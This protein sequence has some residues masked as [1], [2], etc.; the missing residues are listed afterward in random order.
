MASLVPADLSAKNG[1]PSAPTA[2]PNAWFGLGYTD[3]SQRS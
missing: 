3:V 2:V 1:S